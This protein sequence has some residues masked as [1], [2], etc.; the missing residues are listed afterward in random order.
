MPKRATS[1]M[2]QYNKMSKTSDGFA[3]RESFLDKLKYE[4]KTDNN[5]IINDQPKEE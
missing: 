1:T 4:N 5:T 3:K 2:L